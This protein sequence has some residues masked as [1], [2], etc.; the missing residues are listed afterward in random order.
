MKVPRPHRPWAPATL[1]SDVNPVQNPLKIKVR[2]RQSSAWGWIA[3]LLSVLLIGLVIGVPRFL[4]VLQGKRADAVALEIAGHFA[5]IKPQVERFVIDRGGWETLLP[6]QFDEARRGYGG[7]FDTLGT[8]AGRPVP[9]P[10]AF[11]TAAEQRYALEVGDYTGGRG[12]DHILVLRGP[13]EG[14]CRSFNS[15]QDKPA[16]PY[17]VD[18]GDRYSR[19][20]GCIV[21]PDNGELVVFM[22]L[23]AS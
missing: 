3:F 13:K 8:G 10:A 19:G 22:V 21:D 1:E 14:V 4:D 7:V 16:D 11:A 23:N 18:P 12:L 6:E 17:S 9:P 2:R 5:A 20:S 15:V